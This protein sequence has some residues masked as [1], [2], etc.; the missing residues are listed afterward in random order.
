MSPSR[1]ILSI[2]DLS[3]KIKFL[4]M[5]GNK[6]ILC[7][8]VFDLLHPGHI[9]H[10]QAAKALGHKLAV[11][12]TPDRFVNKGPSRPAFTEALRAEAI[13]ECESV[14]FV[15]IN[16]W[17]T[18]V[19]TIKKL[20]PHVFVKGREYA[21]PNSDE[22]RGIILEKEAIE[23][24]G[25]VIHFTDEITFSSS[26]LLNEHFGI[27]P[28]S[29][30]EFLREFRRR[31]S[32]ENVIRMLK[33][34]SDLRV[35]VI[36]ETILDEYVFVAP[37]GKP[38]KGNHIAACLLKS[39]IHAGGILA[40]ANHLANFCGTVDL[41]SAI[42]HDGDEA[43]IASRMKSNVNLHF[44]HYDKAPTIVKTRFVDNAFL[45]KLFETYKI[46][47]RPSPVLERQVIAQL[48]ELFNRPSYYD[49]ILVLD[50]GHGMLTPDVINLICNRRPAFLAVNAQTNTANMGFNLITKYPTANYFCLDDKELRLA[51]HDNFSDIK[52]LIL[53]LTDR[54]ALPG[55]I[56]VTRGH[57]GVTSYNL[58]KRELYEVPVLSQK[59]VDTTGAGDA[60]FAITAA[61][62]AK[63][64][65]MDLVAFIGNA[66]G[67]LAVGILGN[68]S[69]VEAAPLFK[70]ITAL[71]K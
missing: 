5:G 64:F 47:D 52:D 28:A 13:A 65:P 7:H 40:C 24:V 35:L 31:Y 30:Q 70:F 19:E 45:S 54:V 3:S 8:G 14:D 23:E 10:F 11:T 27:Y 43:F 17:P 20:K 71:L 51:F 50:Y 29:A 68:K 36:G 1:K 61:C 25:S 37:I 26:S 44:L 48:I 57:L 38:P 60:F 66:V 34:L 46:D 63:G 56:S 59:V 22:T 2:D 16:E 62:V 49:L 53:K 6:I 4:K 67:A 41:L 18:A 21:D 33:T 32:A 58:E 55:G 15:A 39:E 12:I 69:S 9:K 42:G